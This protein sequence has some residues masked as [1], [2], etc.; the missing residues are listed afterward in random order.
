MFLCNS[1]QPM[2]FFCCASTIGWLADMVVTFLISAT[3][4]TTLLFCS[5]SVAYSRCIKGIHTILEF[6][7]SADPSRFPYRSN[8]AD[9][10]LVFPSL[11]THFYQPIYRLRGQLYTCRSHTLNHTPIGC[12]SLDCCTDVIEPIQL[13]LV[14]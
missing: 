6:L 1:C 12:T 9:Q 13:H 2:H 8:T 5:T 10:S 7:L 14:A 4:D 11:S 3:A